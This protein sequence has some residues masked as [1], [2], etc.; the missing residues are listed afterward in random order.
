MS[1]NPQLCA[2]L[3]SDGFNGEPADRKTKLYAISA[4]F[5]AGIE[6]LKRLVAI[7]RPLVATSSPALVASLTESLDFLESHCCHYLLL[8]TIEL[9]IMNCNTEGEL[10]ESVNR[11]IAECVRVGDAIDALPAD[12]TEAGAR[13]IAATRQRSN[14]PLAAF[15]GLRLD[16]N[17]DNGRS[18]T[19]YPFGLAWSDVLYFHIRNRAAFAAK[20]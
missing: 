18:G 19:E 8:E 10:R 7:L 5:K 13:L 9:D 16:D 2:S 11:E 4:E 6:R 1:G 3:I 17:F 14:S 15:Y 12:T 20:D